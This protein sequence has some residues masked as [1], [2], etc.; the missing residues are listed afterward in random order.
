MSNENTNRV[1]A[2]AGA[3]E[4][5]KEQTEAVTGGFRSFIL[6]NPLTHPDVKFD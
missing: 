3:R 2:R 4:L 1:L 5:T 6:T